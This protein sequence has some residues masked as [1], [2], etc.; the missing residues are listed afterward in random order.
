MDWR[1]QAAGRQF[2][3]LVH[4]PRRELMAASREVDV[5]RRNGQT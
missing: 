5:G 2:R 4:M 1:K 3:T